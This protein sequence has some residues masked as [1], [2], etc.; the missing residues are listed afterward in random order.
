VEGLV[1]ISTPDANA[2]LEITAFPLAVLVTLIDDINYDIRTR[3]QDGGFSR[4]C[5]WQDGPY[6]GCAYLC[7]HKQQL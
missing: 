5:R 7:S 6:P 4:K 3:R 2:S 1:L